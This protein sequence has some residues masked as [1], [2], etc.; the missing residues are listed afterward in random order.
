VRE[1]FVFIV[2]GRAVPMHRQLSRANAEL[3]RARLG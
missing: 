3:Q 1:V 2:F